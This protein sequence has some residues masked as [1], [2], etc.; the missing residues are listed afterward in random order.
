M[1]IS[2][3]KSFWIGFAVTAALTAWIYWIWRQ[4]REVVPEPL[5]VGRRSSPP[6]FPEEQTVAAK[7]ELLVSEPLEEIRGIGPVFAAGLGIFA[8]AVSFMVLVTVCGQHV[9]ED[10]EA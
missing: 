1:K 4:K 2:Y 10:H 6:T 7:Q 8:A 3:V 9:G 5:V